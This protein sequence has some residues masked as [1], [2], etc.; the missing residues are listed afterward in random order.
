M[1]PKANPQLQVF[2]NG[3]VQWSGP[4]SVCLC[5]H[6]GDGDESQHDDNEVALGHGE[7]L[8]CKCEK[9]TWVAFLPE[10]QVGL[11]RGL[12]F[13]GLLPLGAS[14]QDNV[15]SNEVLEERLRLSGNP[16]RRSNP[17]GPDKFRE[18]HHGGEPT[19]IHEYQTQDGEDREIDLVVLGACPALSW[20]HETCPGCKPH[21]VAEIYSREGSSEKSDFEFEGHRIEF[22]GRDRPWLACDPLGNKLY[23]VGGAIKRLR[24]RHGDMPGQAPLA[25]YVVDKVSVPSSNK[26]GHYVHQLGPYVLPA[27]TWD[28]SVEGYAFV[29]GSY[30]VADWIEG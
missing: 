26:H 19:R 25:E 11:T 3:P 13:I 24:G 8:V 4:K 5:G 15:D 7:C 9:F 2:E 6:T 1:K 27:L 16:G 17:D 29:G 22:Y 30:I 12:K 18:F 14:E 28:E 23:V 10:Y 20:Q 21:V